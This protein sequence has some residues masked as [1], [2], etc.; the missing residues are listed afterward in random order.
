MSCVVIDIGNTSTAV[1]LARHGRISR[2]CHLHGGL[3]DPQAIKHVLKGLLDADRVDGMALCSVVPAANS[4]WMHAIKQLTGRPPLVIS[5]RLKLGVKVRYP[6]PA[7]IGA[8]RLANA[9]GAMARYG[10]PAIVADFGTAVTFDILSKDGAYVGGVIAPG[11]PLMTQYLAEKTA[12]LPLIQLKG[13]CRTVG[14]STESA[15]KIGAKIGYRGMVR[16][17]VAHICGGTAMK[18]VALCATG[19]YARWALEDIGMPF[20]IDPDLTLFGIARIFDLNA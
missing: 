14:R 5:H 17:I 6:K 7:S 12:L 3:K 4:A 20:V 18:K 11:I 15:M 2:V 1:G 10:C 13:K 16:E 19:G 9:S 8:D